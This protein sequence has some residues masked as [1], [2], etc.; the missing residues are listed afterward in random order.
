MANERPVCSAGAMPG[1]C[2]MSRMSFVAR[3][4]L[5]VASVFLVAAGA[6][7]ANVVTYHYDNQRTG[8]NSSETTLT[9]AAVASTSFGLLSQTT[10]DEQVDA[11]PLFLSAQQI[12]GGTYDVVY[13]ATENNTVYAIDSA[14]G[15][16]LL[17]NNLGKAVPISALPG[18]CNNNSNNIGINSTPVIDLAA[19]VMYVVTYT[20]ESRRQV[21]RL[22]QLSLTSLQDVVPSVVV[23]A[24]ALLK[25]GETETFNAATQRQRP[26][27]IETSGNIYAG[28]GSFCDISANLSR[29]WVLGWNAATLAPV[30]TSELINKKPKTPDN[31]FLSSVW[32]SGYGIASDDQGSLFFLTGNTDYSGTAYNKN[33]N[34]A[35]SVVRLSADLTTVQGFFTPSNHGSLDQGDTDFGSGGVLLLPT[36]NGSA[37]SMAVA[38]GKGDSMYLLNRDALGGV[39]GHSDILGQYANNGCWCGQSYY[40]GSDGVGRVVSSTGGNTA[41]WTV[42]SS[43]RPALKLESR[44]PNLNSGQDPGFFTTVSSNGTAANTAVVWALPHPANTTI[45]LAAMDPSNG[46]AELFSAPAGSWPFS[47]NAN[48]NLVP[49][50]A[51]GHVFVASYENLS[52]FGLSGNA[53]HAAFRPAAPPAPDIFAGAA[54]DVYGIVVAMEGATLSLRTRTGTIVKVDLAAAR[55]GGNVAEPTVGHGA[56][57]RGDYDRA[58]VLVAK[59]VLH[60]RDNAALW[61]ADR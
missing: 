36:Q 26:G 12:A 4:A 50:V 42:Q 11:Q 9:P 29:G 39:G 8:W 34:V 7:A 61:P 2:H 16:V 53:R 6:N 15:N 21:F 60:A 56:L 46:S 54:H 32:M 3:H 14:T 25:N 38:A 28:F 31:F 35:E 49:V 18:G 40:V 37:P 22:H 52:I 45:N 48:A 57:I 59:F 17:S 19:G 23:R 58:G 30:G 51:N 55:R 47:G 33:Y 44:S 24:T 20:Y 1:G 10:L 13:V 5:F 27:L 43:P 41:V